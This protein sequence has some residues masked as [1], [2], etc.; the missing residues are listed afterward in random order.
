MSMSP[1]H[2]TP[3]ERANKTLSVILQRLAPAGTQA[4]IAVGM[5][6]SESSI[7]RMK[8]HLPDV[9]ALLTGC[10]LKVVD[11]DAECTRRDEL[12]FLRRV[13]ARVMDQ[14]EHLLNEGDA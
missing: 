7:S 9:A 14:A 10:G 2:L 11:V 1:S 5:G 12:A 13:Y 4:A 3:A 8:E 6:K